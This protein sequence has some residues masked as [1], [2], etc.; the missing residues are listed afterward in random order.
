[1][2]AQLSENML[3]IGKQTYLPT[4]IGCITLGSDGTLLRLFQLPTSP[5]SSRWAED[6]AP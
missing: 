6:F 4:E 2:H 1:M 5:A 3:A